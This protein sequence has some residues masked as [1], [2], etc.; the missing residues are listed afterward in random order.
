V[1]A[2]ALQ[3]I[4]DRIN[5]GNIHLTK[6]D[7]ILYTACEIR[8]ATGTCNLVRRLRAENPL[9]AIRSAITAFTTIGALDYVREF[10][11][12]ADE[13]SRAFT[14]YRRRRCLAN[15]EARLLGTQES[16][17]QLIALYAATRQCAGIDSSLE[18][19]FAV[20]LN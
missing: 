6:A 8:S 18:N 12:A 19:P 11:L 14:P 13:Y 3:A 20:A 15:L 7:R 2:H 1:T 16:I 17:D 10:Q 4:F 9:D 5:S